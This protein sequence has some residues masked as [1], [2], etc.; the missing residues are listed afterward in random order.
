M[1]MAPDLDMKLLDL[2]FVDYVCRAITLLARRRQL[3]QDLSGLT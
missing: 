3:R 2:S 1:G